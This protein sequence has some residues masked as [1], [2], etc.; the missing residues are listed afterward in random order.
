MV[1]VMGCSSFALS[2]QNCSI[3][4]SLLVLQWKC[5]IAPEYPSSCQREGIDPAALGKMSVMFPFSVA[6][7]ATSMEELLA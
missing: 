6:G 1:S 7:M 3:R 5:Y 4:S 2:L